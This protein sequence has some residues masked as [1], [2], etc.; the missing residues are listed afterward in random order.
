MAKEL[1]F[2]LI[3]PHSLRK[4]R[5]GG[6][7]GRFSRIEGLEFVAA[8]MFGPSQEL[9]ERYAELVRTHPDV[10]PESQEMLSDYI[11]RAFGPE[12]DTGRPHRTMMLFFEG[13]NAIRK[14]HDAA[15][16]FDDTQESADTVRG[17]YGDSVHDPDGN[18]I[19]FE[20]AVLLGPT[21][22]CA[23]ESIK[24]WLEY[25]EADGGIIR[26]PLSLPE[27]DMQKTL[28]IIKPDNFRFPSSRPGNIIDLFSRS[29][30]RLIG[31]QVHRMSMAEAKEF[32]GPVQKVLR[33]KLC[34]NTTEKA[35]AILE[36]EF[37]FP[38]PD[39]VR[40]A[41]NQTLG[42]SYG[43]HQFYR[44]MQFMTG[45]WLPD[46]PEDEIEED[47]TVR[48]LVLVYAGSDAVNKIR[49]ILGP[50]DPSKAQPGSV[51]KEY[52][53][54]IMVN[55]AHASDSP[56]N[57]KREMGILKPERNALKK[58]FDLYYS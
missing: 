15:G 33:E 13:E 53:S 34:C 36:D 56:E 18:L 50:T 16:G 29:G 24:L 41:L 17:T 58:W 8:R 6:I 14:I 21:L 51:R 10:T 5:T 38:M 46:V 19:Y 11:L 12:T 28:V 44:I 26:N 45:L 52:G 49:T 9:V 37:G 4:S 43:D 55:A 47:G 48:C 22:D 3:T 39:N 31:A 30:L 32:Y 23:R 42:L 1:G 20:P 27:E 40:E 25:A 2:V 54:D 35:C 57:A 7:I